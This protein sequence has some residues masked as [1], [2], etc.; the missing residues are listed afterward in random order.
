MAGKFIQCLFQ[1]VTKSSVKLIWQ[2]LKVKIQD[3]DIIWLDWREK[4]FVILASAE[5]LKYSIRLLIHYLKFEDVPIPYSSNHLD[6]LIWTLFDLPSSAVIAQSYLN[7]ATPF[8]IQSVFN[9]ALRL[10]L[11]L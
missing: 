4:L 1:I 2:E 8:F 5:M 7:S 11:I 9:Q 10:R 3:S 6:T